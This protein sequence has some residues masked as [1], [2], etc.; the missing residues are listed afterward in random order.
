MIRN[1]REAN[2][3]LKLNRD[4]LSE[5]NSNLQNDLKWDIM[6]FLII[7]LSCHYF[8]NGIRQESC[9]YDQYF[10]AASMSDQ[11]YLLE[12]PLFHTIP[13]LRVFFFCWVWQVVAE[14]G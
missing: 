2:V 1:S 6:T 14:H 7:A 3:F 8:E 10:L 9:M 4:I 12:L 11:C 5:T 13:I